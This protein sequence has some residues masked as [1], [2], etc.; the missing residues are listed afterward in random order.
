MSSGYDRQAGLVSRLASARFV[1][2]ESSVKYGRWRFEVCTVKFADAAERLVGLGSTVRTAWFGSNS[3]EIR[4]SAL[5]GCGREFVYS[6]T[7]RVKASSWVIG[8]FVVVVPVL[9]KRVASRNSALYKC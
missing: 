5:L 2:H 3:F 6:R 8:V 9:W 4:R 7:G 1:E